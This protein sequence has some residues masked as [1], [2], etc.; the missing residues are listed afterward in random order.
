M[1]RDK[2]EEEITSYWT[3]ARIDGQPLKSHVE[4]DLDL[5]CFP[6]LHPDGKHGENDPGRQ[7]SIAKSN[8]GQLRLMSIDP[9]FRQSIPYNFFLHNRRTFRDISSGV[10]S[11]L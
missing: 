1:N 11:K 4:R 7:V 6:D 5:M 9:R 8:Y 2:V 10:Y 3:K